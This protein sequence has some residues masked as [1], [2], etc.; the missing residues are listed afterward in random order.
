MSIQPTFVGRGEWNLAALQSSIFGWLADTAVCQPDNEG[1][2]EFSLRTLSD[3]ATGCHQPSEIFSD[4]NMSPPEGED[5]NTYNPD[6]DEWAWESIEEAADKDSEAIQKA[7]KNDAAFVA[8][9]DDKGIVDWQVY[10][11]HREHNGDY[12]LFFGYTTPTLEG[13]L[14]A[15]KVN[16][17]NG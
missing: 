4:L 12:C 5:P 7:L 3:G 10:F 11:G 9:L 16:D 1:R 14:N 6:E 8:Q 15:D 2:V 13:D 17:A